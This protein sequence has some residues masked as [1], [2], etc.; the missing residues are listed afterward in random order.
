[1]VSRR[2]LQALKGI[3]GQQKKPVF[4]AA[5]EDRLSPA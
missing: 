1:M 2:S 5:A 4:R 3:S